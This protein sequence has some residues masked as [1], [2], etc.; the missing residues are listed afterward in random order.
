M[1]IS[2]SSNKRSHKY[3]DLI[4]KKGENQQTSLDK[5]TEVLTVKEL[6]RS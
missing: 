5:P 1:Q 4:E 6:L 2:D 3:L